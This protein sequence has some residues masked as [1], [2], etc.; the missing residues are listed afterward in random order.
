MNKPDKLLWNIIIY[1]MYTSSERNNRKNQ[2]SNERGESNGENA[3][4][5]NKPKL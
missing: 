2:N 3:K 4:T 5:K 1:Q